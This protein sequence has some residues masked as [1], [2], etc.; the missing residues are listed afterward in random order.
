LRKAPALERHLLPIVCLLRV[1]VL[2]DA[3]WRPFDEQPL[4]AVSGPVEGRHELVLRFER[5]GV[6]TRERRSLALSVHTGLDREW[7]ESAFSRIA[8]HFP[9]AVLLE[10][11]GV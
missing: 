1:A 2:E 10:Q 6:D 5:Y 8:F 9:R 3:V 4:P 11:L 7:I